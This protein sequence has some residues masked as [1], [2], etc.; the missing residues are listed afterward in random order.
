MTLQQMEYILAVD[1]FRHFARAAAHCH[2]TQPTLS[3]MV[4][5]LEEEL[6]ATIF[7]RT[8]QPVRP[9]AVG[10]RILQQARIALAQA[11]AVRQVVAEEKHSLAGLFRLGI[12]P[13]IAPYLLPRFF[14]QL[15]RQYPQLDIRV[16]EMR[17]DALK[18]AL[19][20]GSIDAGIVA[21]LPGMDAFACTTLFY[22]PFLAYV[23]RTDALFSHDLIRTSDLANAQLWLLDEGHCLR[24]QMVKFCQIES[25]RANREVYRLGSMETFMRMVEGG[26]GVT[27]IPGLAVESL[28]PAQREL[29]RPFAI[30]RPVRQI[31]LL[32]DRLFIRHTL[33]EV[34]ARE[35]RA[36]VPTEMLELQPNQVAI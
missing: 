22:E 18:T 15:R 23:S 1:R 2:V 29:V 25:V 5:K 4:Q 33:L 16:V 26:E 8:R 30:P 36:S 14:P 9:T 21:L 32:T 17:T 3:M 7:D 34:V 6:G 11:D 35:I 27:F 10:T 31:V 13:T 20:E 12:L 19:R 24:D 28:S